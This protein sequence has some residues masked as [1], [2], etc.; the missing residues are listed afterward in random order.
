M[1]SISEKGSTTKRKIKVTHTGHLV[2]LILPNEVIEKSKPQPMIGATRSNNFE[3]TKS[4]SKISE[5]MNDVPLEQRKHDHV[6]DEISTSNHN[7]KPYFLDTNGQIE[8]NSKHDTST[9]SP[10]PNTDTH[11]I[12]PSSH[13]DYHGMS[14]RTS[15]NPSCSISHY[16]SFKFTAQNPVCCT[17][18]DDKLDAEAKACFEKRNLKETK[19][20]ILNWK[21][22]L[23]KLNYKSPSSLRFTSLNREVEQDLGEFSTAVDHS[24]WN[25]INCHNL[26]N[27]PKFY[28]D[29]PHSP[30]P[31]KFVK[32]GTDYLDVRKKYKATLESAM[33][34]N[35]YMCKHSLTLRNAFGVQNVPQ[36]S[37]SSVN[38]LNAE[39]DMMEHSRDDGKERKM[40]TTT[41][42][43][44]ATI[45]PLK[46]S[47]TAKFS[48][49]TSLRKRKVCVF[50]KPAITINIPSNVCIYNRFILSLSEWHKWKFGPTCHVN[51][52]TGSSNHFKIQLQQKFTITE[53]NVILQSTN[54]KLLLKTNPE[55]ASEI[56]GLHMPTVPLTVVMFG[57]LPTVALKNCFTLNS[58]DYRQERLPCYQSSNKNFIAQQSTSN[59]NCSRKSIE[60]LL[61]GK[62]YAIVEPQLRNVHV[63]CSNTFSSMTLTMY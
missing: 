7:K 53:N 57:V 58:C 13:T 40:F 44:Q 60:L 38:S 6:Y 48:G 56:L 54:P 36:S 33:K 20:A 32:F 55:F 43:N 25:S 1:Y 52:R 34:R 35:N 24:C 12:E 45:Q 5:G 37:I 42:V 28:A 14:S 26:K 8:K 18:H 61:H 62:T 4:I 9:L 46:N 50:I 21:S 27:F 59:D 29:S 19:G 51:K 31:I 39:L 23:M 15:P 63:R 10:N 30:L 49:S 17:S 2:V 16:D 11:L 47:T 3:I 41:E 22:E